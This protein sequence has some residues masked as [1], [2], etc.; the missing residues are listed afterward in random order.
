MV[1][2]DFWCLYK[3]IL[4]PNELQRHQGGC[5]LLIQNKM[6]TLQL[7]KTDIVFKKGKQLY[8]YVHVIIVTEP[9]PD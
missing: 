1:G 2:I 7:L 6:A 4:L 9:V 3:K 5:P 8:M